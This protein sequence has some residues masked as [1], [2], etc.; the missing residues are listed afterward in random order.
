MKILQITAFYPPSLGG[1]QLFVQ[2]LS[3]SLVEIG[4]QVDVLTINTEYVVPEEITPHGIRIQRCKQDFNYHRGLFSLEFFF[5]MLASRAYDIFHIHVPFPYGLEVAV[6]SSKLSG[7]PIVATHHGQGLHGNIMYTAIAG[8]YSIFSRVISFRLLNTIVFLTRSYAQSIWLPNGLRQ[9]IRIVPTGADLDTFLPARNGYQIRKK[10]AVPE[11]SPLLIFVGH[12]GKTNR[13][14]GIDILI[15]ALNKVLKEVEDVK[16]L[17]IGGG[18]WLPEL[19]SLSRK[20]NLE[21]A[22]IFAGPVENQF[23]PDYYAAADVFVLPSLRG[24]ENSP[25]V[26]FEAMASGLPAIASDLPGVNEIVRQEETG[27][28]VEPRNTLELSAA[29]V[30]VLLDTDFQS[31]AGKKARIF[32]ER[33]SWDQC[34]QDMKIL[35]RELIN[36]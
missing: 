4:H 19:K 27:V 16:L 21:D 28:L 13:Y 29:I 18:D 17:I 23:L 32:A 15:K 25:V 30:R 14:K 6:L 22:I 33:Y 31:S 8:S 3:K 2:S 10:Y 36:G 34:A 35:Y 12:L 9:K 1:I 20:L 11:S 26:L 5:R 7:I 24:P